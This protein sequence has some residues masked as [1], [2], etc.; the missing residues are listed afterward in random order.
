M[1]VAGSE[2]CSINIIF[3]FFFN[4]C[5]LTHT[6]TSTPINMDLLFVQFDN[7]GLPK[8]LR[9]LEFVLQTCSRA[10]VSCLSHSHLMLVFFEE[11]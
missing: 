6:H 4:V 1:K 2:R 9:I 5:A 3:L 8:D 7:T 10:T 11:E